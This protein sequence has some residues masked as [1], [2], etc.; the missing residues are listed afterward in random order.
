VNIENE[1]DSLFIS[2]DLQTPSSPITETEDEPI[3]DSFLP[4][5]KES[6][7]DYLLPDSHLSLDE[8]EVEKIED[9]EEKF[10][11]FANI[12]DKPR[13]RQLS[14]S[15]P[16][17]QIMIG[18]AVVIALLASSGA[19]VLHRSC[20]IF[21]CKE[22]QTA[23]QFKS[24]Y[25]QQIKRTKS[26]KDLLTMQQQ[27]DKVQALSELA[28]DVV[29]TTLRDY[30]NQD[31]RDREFS[32]PLAV[33]KSNESKIFLE[34]HDHDYSDRNAWTTTVYEMQGSTTS[35]AGPFARRSMFFKQL[36][37]FSIDAG[38]KD[39]YVHKNLMYKSLI[40]KNYEHVISIRALK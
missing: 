15:L 33:R 36:A 5:S 18:T 37:K 2:A 39:F 25:Q 13:N 6:F 11:P 23:Q 20:V 10:A 22:L 19:F 38:A 1:R 12:A 26:Q 24:Q 3:I 31:F 4:S 29:I 40:K 16:P 28:K 27:L 35:A 17:V 8:N 30:K 7:S 14:L 9:I 32:Q 21:E 34:Y